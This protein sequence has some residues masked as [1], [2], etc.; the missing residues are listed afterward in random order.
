[1]AEISL[2]DAGESVELEN[3]DYNQYTMSCSPDGRYMTVASTE[4]GTWQVYV[5]GLADDKGKW[6]ISTDNGWDA[7]WS[8]DGSEIFYERGDSTI[9]TVPVHTEGGFRADEPKE[10]FHRDIHSV[11]AKRLRYQPSPDGQRFLINEQ[12]V[13]REASNI[14]VVLNWRSDKRFK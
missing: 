7:V 12:L 2:A 13:T 8:S 10:L 4:S 5:R 11:S 3:L 1:M 6:Q 9:I 14:I